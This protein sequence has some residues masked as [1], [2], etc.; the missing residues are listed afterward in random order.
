[1]K[2]VSM[3]LLIAALVCT[4]A[5]GAGDVTTGASGTTDGSTPSTMASSTAPTQSTTTIPTDSTTASSSATIPTETDALIPELPSTTQS[6]V[7]TVEETVPTY[8]IPA[9]TESTTPDKVNDTFAFDAKLSGTNVIAFG[10]AFS[11]EV[12]T[13]NISGKDF[14]YVGSSRI[15]GAT[16]YLSTEVDGRTVTMQPEGVIMPKNIDRRVIANGEVITMEWTFSDYIDVVPGTYDL[17]FSF[18]GY[19]GVLEDFLTIENP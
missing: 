14:S 8:G 4:T 5:C 10:H 18:Q 7:P 16:V 9:P 2:K 11:M 1:M 3:L 15:V 19:K 17:H 6:T 13:T 12:T